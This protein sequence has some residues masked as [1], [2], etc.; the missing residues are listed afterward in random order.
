M[1]NISTFIVIPLLFVAT[2]SFSQFNAISNSP[3]S[4]D[5]LESKG[6]AWIDYD[7]DGDDDLF[8]TTSYHESQPR[9]NLLYNNNGDGTF[10]KIM[11]GDLVN[12]EA[13]GRNSSWADFN[14]DGLIDVFV[15]NQHENF[16]YK[17]CG[18][19]FLPNNYLFR[20]PYSHSTV[21]T[22]EGPGETTME[23]AMSIYFYP[24]INSLT[25][26]EM[27]FT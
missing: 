14:N 15:V 23:T 9:K 2:R 22:V 18:E 10:S 7:N 19:E 27:Y 11:S 4:S 17:N 20:Q 5:G 13:T 21:I 8:V 12:V 25:T 3:L 1:K 24:L 26:Q 16:L 6:V